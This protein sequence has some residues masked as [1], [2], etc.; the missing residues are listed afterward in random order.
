VQLRSRELAVQLAPH[1]GGKITSLID[2]ADGHELLFQL[3]GAPPA[4][5]PDPTR[6][7][8]SYYAAWDEC[9]PA[10]AAGPYPAPPYL[11]V[12]VPDHGELWSQAAAVHHD[13]RSATTSWRSA[14]F[15]YQLERELALDGATLTASYTLRNPAA[16]ELRFVYATHA[17]LAMTAPVELRLPSDE[18]WRHSHGADGRAVGRAFRWPALPSPEATLDLARPTALPAG[19][20]WKLFSERPATY[21][22]L[23]Y[24]TRRRALTVEYRSRDAVAA[25]WGVWINTGG[26]AGHRHL[27]VEPTTGRYDALDASVAD[28][29]AGRVAGGATARWQV[30]LTVE[31]ERG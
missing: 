22:R 12:A 31:A 10:V 7:D 20:A 11:G 25:Y 4:Q 26:W 5:P 19:G 30:A 21:L 15:G 13:E 9:F 6:Y 14:R 24:P 17:L 29:S 23:C 2:L 16:H 18:P 3:P 8:H 1:L 27:A 28:G